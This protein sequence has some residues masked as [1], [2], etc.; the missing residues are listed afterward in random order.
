MGLFLRE[1]RKDGGEGKGGM[2]REGS[3]PTFQARGEEEGQPPK[4]NNGTSPMSVDCA[5]THVAWLK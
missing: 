2:R 4:P 3:G 5:C 1:V